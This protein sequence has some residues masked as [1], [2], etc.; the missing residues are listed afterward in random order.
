MSEKFEKKINGYFI[1]PLIFT[2]KFVKSCDVCVCSGE[3]CYYGVYTDKK[4]YEQIMAIKERIKSSMDDSQTT[5]DSK[6][7]EEPEEDEDFE[8]GIAVGTELYNGKCVFLDRQGYCTLQKV[9]MEDDE[10]KWKY[11]PLYCILFPL[12]I[13]DGAITVDDEHLARLHY[14]SKIDNQNSTIYDCCQEELEYLL[15]KNGMIELNEYREQYF[16]KENLRKGKSG[17]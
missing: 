3:C 6:W 16:N 14:C 17:N 2:H 7:F 13:W 9:A 5:D 11:K 12:I 8:S 15:G 10:F 1:D 4:E